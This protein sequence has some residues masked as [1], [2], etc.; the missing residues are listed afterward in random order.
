MASCNC[1][2]LSI[3]FGLI[4]KRSTNLVSLFCYVYQVCC[5]YFMLWF[6]DDAFPG[7][8]PFFWAVV[9]LVWDSSLPSSS[10][11][12]CFLFGS[13]F[14][15][16]FAADT[17]FG[18]KLRTKFKSFLNAIDRYEFKHIRTVIQRLYL[19]VYIIIY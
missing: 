5:T 19:I 2:I 6:T 8:S 17:S 11:S 16:S 7:F 14:A 1:K 18:S 3:L 4:R 15:T 10:L 13:C 9:V 12:A